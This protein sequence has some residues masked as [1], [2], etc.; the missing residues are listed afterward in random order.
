MKA[1][2]HKITSKTPHLFSDGLK[3]DCHETDKACH[4]LFEFFKDSVINVADA[5]PCFDDEVARSLRRLAILF[6][7]YL[8]IYLFFFFW[9]G[10]GSIFLKLL[11][12]CCP[13]NSCSF[14]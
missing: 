5:Q 10:G 3:C 2:D 8:F 4:V 14:S 9:G 12:A 7:I 11:K 6:N 13:E 1:F